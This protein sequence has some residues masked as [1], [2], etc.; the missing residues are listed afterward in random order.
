[1]QDVRLIG[2][3][4]GRRS[5]GIAYVEFLEIES[6]QKVWTMRSDRLRHSLAQKMCGSKQKSSIKVY[7]ENQMKLISITIS[8][9]D[10]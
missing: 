1:M 8:I 3:K 4:H 2:D 5:K 10:L 9:W 7:K 6:V